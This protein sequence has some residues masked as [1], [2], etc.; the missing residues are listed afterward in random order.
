MIES[1]DLVVAERLRLQEMREE[2]EGKQRQA[3]IE[4][5][6]ERAKIAR[7]RL[8]LQEQIRSNEITN[9]PRTE[10]EQKQDRPRGR[11]LARLGLRDE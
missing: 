2:W 9:P 1:D 7:E 3:E 11:W 4:M 5:S 10:E 8:D 6:M